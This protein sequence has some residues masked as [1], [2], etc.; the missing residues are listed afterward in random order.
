MALR[1]GYVRADSERKA[2]YRA[3]GI[4]K[5]Y[6]PQRFRFGSRPFPYTAAPPQRTRAF[7]CNPTLPVPEA[8]IRATYEILFA[9]Y[10]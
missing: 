10:S 4:S 3:N 8:G 7:R 2:E 9:S 1:W 5:C 6:D